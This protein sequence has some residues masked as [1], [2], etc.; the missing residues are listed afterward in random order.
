MLFGLPQGLF[1]TATQAAVYIQAP[2]DAIG[3]A[4]GLQR[5]AGYLGAIAAT[6][7]LALMYGQRATDHGFH[8]LA[9]VLGVLSAFLLVVT[10]FDR[11]LPRGP[12]G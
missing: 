9:V 3:T 12:V 6:S 11:T 8:G 2:A 4:A 5:T 7:L 10:I 1:S